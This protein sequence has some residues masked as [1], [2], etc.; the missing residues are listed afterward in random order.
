[1]A[2]QLET[3]LRTMVYVELRAS[4]VDWEEPIKKSVSKWPPASLTSDKTLHHMATPHQAALSYL[5]FGQLWS[6]ISDAAMWPLFEPYFPP[7]SNVEVKVEEVKAIRNR[8]AHFREPH[9]NDESRFRLFLQDMEPGVRSFCERYCVDKVPVDPADDVVTDELAKSWQQIGYG[10]ELRRPLGWLY[11]PSRHREAP[12]LNAQLHLLT[13]RNYKR[14]SLE[15]VIYKVTFSNNKPNEAFDIVSF[16]ENTQGLHKD[17]IHIL[18][19]SP[20]YEPAVTIPAIHGVEATAELIAKF[21][22]MGLDNR[23]SNSRRNL[24]RAKLKW[25]EY[26]LWPGHMLTF[27]DEDM[28]ETVLSLE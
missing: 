11:A 28:R 16:V 7:K 27:F 10:I 1:M 6:V 25:P 8:V 9:P 3:W 4:R 18:L 21:L 12:L 23:H 26:V 19:P 20:E 13:H 22:R 15:G 5:T 17:I 24:D 2:W 14:G